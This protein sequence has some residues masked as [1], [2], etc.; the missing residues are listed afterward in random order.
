[1]HS[2]LHR[3]FIGVSVLAGLAL[4]ASVGCRRNTSTK[5]S[6]AP[7][8]RVRDDDSLSLAR[9]GFKK[10]S[11]V[12]TSRQ[13]VQQLNTHINQSADRRPPSLTDS[14]RAFLT[15]DVGL[16]ADELAEVNSPAFT[17]LDAHYLDMCGLLRDAARSL[18]GANQP[19]L[20]RAEAAF[21]WVVRQVRL[22]VRE[23][24]N[25]AEPLP[26]Q[27]V[28][29][30]GWGS[31]VERAFVF[32][33]LLQQL[34]IDG[35][36]LTIPGNSDARRYWIPG[37]LI[38]KDVYLFDTRM[39]IPLPSPSGAGTS[40]LRQLRESDAPFV[41]LDIDKKYP[42]DV[43]AEDLKQAEVHLS[44]PLTA[45]APRMKHLELMLEP[46]KIVLSVDLPALR[47]RFADTIPSGTI[48]VSINNRPSALASV[49]AVRAIREFLPVSEG[50]TDTTTPPRK[51]REEAALIPFGHLPVEILK[52]NYSNAVLVRNLQL[53][54]AL[55]FV[56]F[57]LPNQRSDSDTA[58][59]R[60]DKLMQNQ[61][62]AMSTGQ[63]P[64]DPVQRF[65]TNL[66]MPER[67]TSVTAI[68][69]SLAPKSIRDD[70]LRG[71]FDEAVEELAQAFEQV[72]VQKALGRSASDLNEK[73]Q[74]W[75]ESA[76][77]AQAQ[78]QRAQRQN[79]P[80]EL[81]A[82]Q[83]RLNALWFGEVSSSSNP[84]GSQRVGKA[85]ATRL[86]VWM[87]WLLSHTA[88]LLGAEASYLL[89]LCKQEQAER[90]QASPKRYKEDQI[91][92]AWRTADGYWSQFLDEYPQAPMAAAAR[93][94]KARALEAL[95]DKA[96]AAA[97]LLNLPEGPPSLEA[98][99]RMLRAKAL[100]Q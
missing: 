65:A 7:A 83:N 44:H 4:W 20:A 5:P 66:L 11:G 15:T 45:M 8:T 21:A 56:Q 90:A 63:I 2:Y 3:S 24:V 49:S 53:T 86:P 17:L 62:R 67:A 14:E 29:R 80:P 99:G 39:G 50:G 27:F 68:H 85:T 55:L 69:Y 89:A 60:P 28:L 70:L 57:P 87:V 35:C 52:S 78:V 81:T 32:L 61:G 25:E 95:G 18:T 34:G 6:T 58:A 41:A 37:A 16:N 31:P 13:V 22:P 77:E 9:E 26:P 98:V 76:V 46:N 1:M 84:D 94:C 33:A 74:A 51:E 91:K 93:L 71:R 59:I 79:N 96:G 82:A 12:V 43:T 48:K 47:Q 42:Y 38:D 73:M 64:D 10:I 100:G 30:R 23:R 19:A 75:L 36:M 88:D 97:Q 92:D 54:F 72:S 40:T